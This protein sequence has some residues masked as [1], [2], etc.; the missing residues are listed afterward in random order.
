MTLVTL[1]NG[2]GAQLANR[3]A[4]AWRHKSGSRAICALLVIAIAVGAAPATAEPFTVSARWTWGE[5][6]VDFD[7]LGLALR[8]DPELSVLRLAWERERRGWIPAWTL[9]FYDSTRTAD[10]IEALPLNTLSPRAGESYEAVVSFHPDA[11]AVHAALYRMEKDGSRTRLASDA[12]S[13]RASGDLTPIASNIPPDAGEL[14][15]LEV[16]GGFQPVGDTIVSG[17]ETASGGI[18]P[19]RHIPLGGAVAVRIDSPVPLPGKYQVRL[20]HEAHPE[21]NREAHSEVHPAN[22][23][24]EPLEVT[25]EQGHGGE[26]RVP[27]AGIPPGPVRLVVAYVEGGHS[28]VLHDDRLIVG[29][30]DAEIRLDEVDRAAGTYRGELY[31]KT[32]VPDVWVEA[33]YE[34]VELTWDGERLAFAEEPA[35]D[36]QTLWAG[37]VGDDS[38]PF[39]LSLPDRTGYWFLRFALATTPEVAVRLEGAETKLRNDLS[40]ETA[41]VAVTDQLSQRILVLDPQVKDWNASEALKWS[42]RPEASNG[43]GAFLG[44]WGNPSGVKLRENDVFGGQWMVVTDSKGLAAIVPYPAGNE[45]KWAQV[46][47]GNPHSAELLPNGNIAVAASTGGW[48]RVY[49]S[50]QGPDA[51][52]YFEFPLKGA[53]GVLWDPANNLLW[54]VGDDHLVALEVLGTPDAPVLKKVIER[55]LPT[56]GGHDLAPVYGEAGR[57]WVTTGSSVYQYD[58]AEDAWIDS[59]FG[60]DALLRRSGVKGVGDLPNGQV[61]AVWPKSGSL[62][63]WT[64]DTVHLFLPDEVRRRDNSAI[65][66]ARVWRAEYQ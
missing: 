7:I 49:A 29:Q 11:G 16:T 20:L 54:A 38:I 39:E 19:T 52:Q 51:S 65:Y 47:G 21:V 10:E 44:A 28:A 63:T 66:K 17:E 42:W 50:S 46:V 13:T 57:L 14:V 56:R 58:K 55:P 33:T 35:G 30:I 15:S 22:R 32:P 48:V 36:W 23:F 64:T 40:A 26:M 34:F 9:R 3:F 60:A 8:D 43:F 1:A 41:W 45:L 37:S 4:S 18:V 27:L 62:Y 31:F 59:Y 12:F 24:A 53:H 2:G 5:Q 61:V 6:P 25:L